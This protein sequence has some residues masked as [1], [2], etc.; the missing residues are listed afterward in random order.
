MNKHGIYL[1]IFL[2]GISQLLAQPGRLQDRADRL[3]AFRIGYFTDRMALTTEEARLFWPVYDA[4]Q[5]EEKAL[6][7]EVQTFQR[8]MRL[9]MDAMSD[10]ELDASLDK[11]LAFKQKEFD[12]AKKYKEKFKEVLPIRKVVAFFRA[13]QEFNRT[14]LNSYKEKLEDRMNQDR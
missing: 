4:Y 8:R 2:A 6:K 5:A 1:L 10:K 12:L 11:F 9:G 3:E 14:L 7:I 13:E